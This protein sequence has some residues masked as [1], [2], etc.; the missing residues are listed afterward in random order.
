MGQRSEILELYFEELH[1][2][3]AA[4]ENSAGF[5]GFMDFSGASVI[6]VPKFSDIRAELIEAGYAPAEADKAIRHEMFKLGLGGMA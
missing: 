2:H 3:D 1:K 5:M 6:E 4:L